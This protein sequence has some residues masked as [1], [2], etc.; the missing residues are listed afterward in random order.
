MGRR[1]AARRPGGA[2]NTRCSSSSLP[3]GSQTDA[4]S[5]SSLL[6]PQQDAPACISIQNGGKDIFFLEKSSS[7]IQ[8][9]DEEDDPA[10]IPWADP[11]DWLLIF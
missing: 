10:S 1:D 7:K 8:I 3:P 6:S 4:A 9:K 5:S 2:A 11:A